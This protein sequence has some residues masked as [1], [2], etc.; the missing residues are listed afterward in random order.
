MT[1]IWHNGLFKKEEPIF[2]M[3]DRIRLGDGVF[4]TMLAIDGV[5]VHASL[6]FDR[7]V[8]HASVLQIPVRMS[9]TSFENNIKS[10]LA[11]NEAQ[12]GRYVVNT[13]VTRGPGD[14]GLQVPTDPEVQ[15][16]IR[17]S[18]APK[19]FPPLHAIVPQTVKR[20]EGSVLSQ[21][22]SLNYGVLIVALQE[23]DR[24]GANEA[25]LLNNKGNVTCATS[26][27]IFAI[28]NKKLYT[29]PLSDGVLDGITRQLMFSK[30]KVI[31]KSL[32]REHM[33]KS[34]GIYLTNSVKGALPL[35]SLDGEKLP[36][37]TVK[38]EQDFHLQ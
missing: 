34:D 3:N 38:I 26:S 2:S 5:P 20:N 21:I 29:P 25:I 32:K 37:P 15:L 27:N 14:R 23:A 36:K 33:F 19:S 12:N 30:Y 9:P 4:D 24:M 11:R 13:L 31:E 6:H 35:L 17:I 10:L 7:L 16:A 1:T 22:K 8:R 18:S 28:K